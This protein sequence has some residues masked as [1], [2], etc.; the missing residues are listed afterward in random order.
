MKEWIGNSDL[1]GSIIPKV[2][3]SFMYFYVRNFYV[4]ENFSDWTL[5]TTRHLV[6][7]ALRSQ[8]TQ[9]VLES[10]QRIF[11][12]NSFK[13]VFLI[14]L[15]AESL[16]SSGYPQ[17]QLL[18]KLNTAVSYSLVFCIFSKKLCQRNNCF[19]WNFFISVT[20]YFQ[21]HYFSS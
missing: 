20:A 9:I 12:A 10:I 18:S 15:E 4:Y 16:E 14:L 1:N 6:S 3:L 2:K 21:P 11:V 8:F 5:K 19:G 13:W 7:K 17:N